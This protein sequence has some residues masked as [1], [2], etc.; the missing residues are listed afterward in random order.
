VTKGDIFP[1][2]ECFQGV[3]RR[4]IFALDY[5]RERREPRAAEPGRPTLP[6]E[7]ATVR[8]HGAQS[9]IYGRPR[10]AMRVGGVEATSKNDSTHFRFSE[11][12]IDDA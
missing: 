1:R 2:I 8:A 9:E 12:K 10:A 7:A 4:K 11:E 6:K 5:S 3:A